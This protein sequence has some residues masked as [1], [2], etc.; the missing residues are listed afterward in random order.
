MI[1]ARTKIFVLGVYTPGEGILGRA[2]ERCT[3]YDECRTMY[4]NGKSHKVRVKLYIVRDKHCVQYTKISR[5]IYETSIVH[6]TRTLTRNT[7]HLSLC[8][9]YCTSH[10]FE[11]SFMIGRNFLVQCT[12]CRVK[13]LFGKCTRHHSNFADRVG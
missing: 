13:V 3:K 9:R 12:K 11:C 4:D 6:C 8:T 1:Y 2:Q 7:R 10:E 5:T